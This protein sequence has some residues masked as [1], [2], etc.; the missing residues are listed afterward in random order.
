MS[1]EV[2]LVQQISLLGSE[3]LPNLR[4]LSVQLA[5]FSDAGSEFFKRRSALVE[6][7]HVQLELLL[8][9]WSKT[10]ADLDDSEAGLVPTL[11]QEVSK[12]TQEEVGILRSLTSKMR[13]NAALLAGVGEA[14]K[15]VME[16]LFQERESVEAGMK[17]IEADLQK[18]QK[19]YESLLR[20][21]RTNG[22]PSAPKPKS[23]KL[24]KAESVESE[25][26]IATKRKIRHNEFVLLHRASNA[27]LKQLE[28]VHIPHIMEQ[29]DLTLKR[30][31]PKFV[32]NGQVSGC[33]S[34][35]CSF[36][37]NFTSLD[38]NQDHVPLDRFHH[39]AR[40][41]F[42]HRSQSCERALRSSGRVA[43]SLR[44]F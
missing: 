7:C 31:K 27:R 18:H 13:T 10:M 22:K 44:H 3:Q 24:D 42:F 17:K 32:L 15:R 34:R 23:K 8:N 36:R 39:V 19:E 28:S 25:A 37:V 40:V 21:E 20:Q 16:N 30:Y 41:R 35:S 1:S 43:F 12:A 33:W 4:K 5:K 11:W 9:S 6:Q 26:S 2:V 38:S 14:S 29:C